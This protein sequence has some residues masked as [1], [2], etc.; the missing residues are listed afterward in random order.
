MQNGSVSEYQSHTICRAL[1]LLCLYEIHFRGDTINLG[2]DN[3][4]NAVQICRKVE[5]LIDNINPTQYAEASN[6]YTCT[7]LIQ[8][9]RW[10]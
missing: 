7:Q 8:E 2:R 9:E 1:E 3:L 4:Y 5:F 10:K 6:C